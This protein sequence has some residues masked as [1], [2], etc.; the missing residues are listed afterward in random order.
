MKKKMFCVTMSLIF[1]VCTSIAAFALEQVGPNGECYTPEEL[2]HETDI[3]VDSIIELLIYLT[4]EH[5][6]ELSIPY[7]RN[8]PTLFFDLRAHILYNSD[9]LS[10]SFVFEQ[11]ELS[12]PPQYCG[13][14]HVFAM[15]GF[16]FVFMCCSN[17]DDLYEINPFAGCRGPYTIGAGNV[18][19]VFGPLTTLPPAAP[20]G[21]PLLAARCLW[22]R[23][24]MTKRCQSCGVSS[25]YVDRPGH[26]G[27]RIF[28]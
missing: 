2:Y 23:T 18:R 25:W 27:W 26:D 14:E 24:T 8:N 4:N 5:G 21:I 20:G 6:F 3:D 16:D 15:D 28:G 7:Q 1:V 11:F 10:Q 19:C 13:T 17:H 12:V 9:R 22:I